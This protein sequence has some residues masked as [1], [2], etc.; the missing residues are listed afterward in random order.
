MFYVFLPF[1]V[2][3]FLIFNGGGGAND[4]VSLLDAD[5]Y[6]KSRG[7]EVSLDKMV[8]QAGKEPV[9]AK[10]QIEQ[11]LSIRVLSE[12]PDIAKTDKR[13]VP[14]LEQIA[15]GKKY[16]DKL[17]FAKEYAGR[18][19]A[20]IKGKAPPVRSMPKDA[21]TDALRWFPEQSTM[22]GSL[23]LR[24]TTKVARDNS[25]QL[26]LALKKM[27]PDLLEKEL[28]KFAVNVGN[29]RL[30]SISFAYQHDAAN[31]RAG[32][33]YFRVTGLANHKDL[34]DYFRNVLPPSVQIKERKG[35]KDEP[36]TVFEFKN[37]H[38]APA[39]ALVGDT[40]LAFAVY[41]D[42]GNPGN[43]SLELLDGILE[44][45]AG[46]KANVTK[47]PLAAALKKVPPT[48]FALFTGELTE[49]LRAGMLGPFS[50]FK[51][52]PKAMH[53]EAV[54]SD[55]EI[56]I[57]LHFTMLNADDAKTFHTDLEGLKEKAIAELK[58]LPARIQI[59][60]KSVKTLTKALEGI[61]LKA[62]GT[63]VTG[64]GTATQETSRAFLELIEKSIRRD[65]GGG[66]PP[67]KEKLKRAG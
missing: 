49:D 19:L 28:F 30:D 26:R 2:L 35:P 29:V 60:E 32:R 56:G 36:I 55:K 59:S 38:D 65:F 1:Q 3:F 64:G 48:A 62:T 46:K 14:L 44:I 41:P 34:A 63:S 18:A 16:Q 6:F 45:R 67:G 27:M 33:L 20:R 66:I 42:R 11:L 52:A 50:P 54:R 23:D 5:N 31:P 21:T 40:D 24:S 22:V 37:Q 57:H 58:N 47:G 15:S 39:F 9:D 17:G 4:L 51:A 7:I 12:D 25:K 13:V 53:A 61:K 43:H 10:T 8:E